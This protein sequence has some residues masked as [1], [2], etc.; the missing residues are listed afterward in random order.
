MHNA[1]GVNENW[2]EQKN[3]DRNAQCEMYRIGQNW[4]LYMTWVWCNDS[5]VALGVIWSEADDNQ[6]NAEYQR[7]EQIY[8]ILTVYLW[9]P[10][11]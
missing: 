9:K 5:I 10:P 3:E 2:D 7:I 4:L 11:I 8:F 6:M 1:F